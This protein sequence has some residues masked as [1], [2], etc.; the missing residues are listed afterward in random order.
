[1][2]RGGLYHRREEN[3][4]S[5]R[6]GGRG[7]EEEGAWLDPADE[8]VV[9]RS[10]RARN[11]ERGES[12]PVRESEERRGS[13]RKRW[14]TRVRRIRRSYQGHRGRVTRLWEQRRGNRLGST[15]VFPTLLLNTSR[16]FRGFCLRTFGRNS[17]RKVVIRGSIR[18][19]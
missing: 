13:K 10:A 3:A 12:S 18:G 19:N 7:E 6:D 5:R 9:P 15:A 14:M 8:Q 16:K 11:P 2:E 4:I 1:M 17:N